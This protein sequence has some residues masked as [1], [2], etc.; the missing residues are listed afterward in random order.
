MKYLTLISVL[1]LTLLAGQASAD[2]ASYT[3]NV[4]PQF[5]KNPVWLDLNSARGKQITKRCYFRKGYAAIFL[6]EETSRYK[7]NTGWL[8]TKIRVYPPYPG[9]FWL[10]P[11][12]SD[13]ALD[14]AAGGDKWEGHA[15]HGG[16]YAKKTGWYNVRVWSRSTGNA[17]F[18]VDDLSLICMN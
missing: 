7:G 5:V 17:T 11:T 10:A 15:T 9:A 13:L 6:S 16:F 18:R 12:N 1:G 2:V 14:S 8:H 3:A 4:N